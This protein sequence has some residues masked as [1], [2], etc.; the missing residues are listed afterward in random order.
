VDLTWVT[1]SPKLPPLQYS[2]YV[3]DAQGRM[4]AQ[5]DGPLGRWPDELESAWAAGEML[6]QRVRLQLPAGA[7]PGSYRVQVGLYTP[8][9]GEGLPLA[10]NGVPDSAGRYLLSKG[11]EVSQP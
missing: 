9:G 2:V 10:V 5:R 4:V 3:T 8:E 1:T 11:K 6:R 7:E